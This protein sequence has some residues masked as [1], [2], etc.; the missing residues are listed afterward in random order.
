MNSSTTIKTKLILEVEG[1]TMSDCEDKVM[2]WA[3]KRLQARLI[4]TPSPVADQQT[5][6]LRPNMAPVII[7]DEVSSKPT[8]ISL[9][10]VV[11]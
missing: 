1:P 5:E 2:E 3:G 9:N 8:K 11:K 7:K 10:E 4:A 6:L